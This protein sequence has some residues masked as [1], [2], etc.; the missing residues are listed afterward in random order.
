MVFKAEE[1]GHE[2][3]AIFNGVSLDS[4]NNYSFLK[5]ISLKLLKESGFNILES[6]EHVFQPQGYTFMVLLSE[7]HFA[8]HTYPE[9]NSIYFH[10]YTCRKRDT[11]KIFSTLKE[12]FNPKEVVLR[13]EVV[14]VKF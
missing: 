12:I 3:T 2:V 14:R 13:K 11:E 6:S 10:L 5:E 7:S 9:Y 4:L 8:L 1:S